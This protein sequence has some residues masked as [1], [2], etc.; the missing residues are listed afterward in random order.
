MFLNGLTSY[1]FVFIS[2]A[3]GIFAEI[4]A[5]PFFALTLQRCNYYRVGKGAEIEQRA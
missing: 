4:R 5:N 1:Y 3:K 2:R